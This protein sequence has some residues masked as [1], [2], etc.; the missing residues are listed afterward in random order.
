MATNI[1]GY[2]ASLKLLTDE[3]SFKKGIGSLKQVVSGVGGL[4]KMVAGLSVV[5]SVFGGAMALMQ[6]DELILAQRTNLATGELSAWSMAVGAAGVSAGQ[7]TGA[8]ASLD[9]RLQRMKLGE[10]DVGLAKSLGMLGIGF[11]GF[12]QADAGKRTEQVLRQAMAMRD[13]RKAA[14]LVADV[15]GSAGQ[16]Y[17]WYL[18][19]SGAS[20]DKQ[21]AE[22]RALTFTNERTKMDALVFSAEL[23]KTGGAMK[24][25]GALWGSAF[26]RQLTPMIQG[27]NR[28]IASNRGLI[29]S[30]VIAFAKDAG[31]VIVEI[32][33]HIVK[34][35]PQA[36]DLINRLGG[37]EAI[38]KRV[39]IGFA[40][41]KVMQLVGGIANIVKGVGGL[42]G[43]LKAMGLSTGPVLLAFAGIYL[44]IQDL[45]SKDSVLKE[46]FGQIVDMLPT[47]TL[48]QFNAIWRNLKEIWGELG[49]I[50]VELAG[51]IGQLVGMLLKIVLPPA[52]KLI[53]DMLSSMTAS[54]R[55]MLAMAAGKEP[56]VAFE[57]SPAGELIGK[58]SDILAK[59]TPVERAVGRW[60]IENP[61]FL[62]SEATAMRL[63]KDW[64]I[65]NWL[66][67]K[68]LATP[69]LLKNL[70][71]NITIEDKTAGGIKATPSGPTGSGR[72]AAAAAVRASQ[73]P[74]TFFPVAP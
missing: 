8:L 69:E 10:V 70:G 50:V 33:G 73:T 29:R 31:R 52:L 20:L 46:L 9:S 24:E 62:F 4:V 57:A 3:T 21:L 14:Q 18:T 7:F 41:W 15:L 28:L 65:G 30:E 2:F 5:R 54:M 32:T 35:I 71:V 48:D 45:L 44:I 58:V 64:G 43:A 49:P 67:E 37:L 34:L 27:I 13:Q 36:I 23:R 17:F 63:I 12:A 68:K 55:E 40:A 72:A 42:T 60:T 19:A 1:G 39:A 56:K 11:G 26:A 66:V 25:I 74:G 59:G 47:E 16:E 22:G 53:A 6:R 51:S 38:V 61:L